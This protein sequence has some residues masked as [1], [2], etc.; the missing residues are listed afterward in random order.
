[1]E[2]GNGYMVLTILCIFSWLGMNQNSM[3]KGK[4]VLMGTIKSHGD[5]GKGKPSIFALLVDDIN[6]MSESE[7]KA[8]WLQ[9]N[10]EKVISLSKAID[11]SVVPHSLSGDEIDELIIEARKYARN[12]KKG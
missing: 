1:M 7:Q 6:R 5:T 12:K 2:V 9:I 10:K 11:S 4:F 3:I 8:L